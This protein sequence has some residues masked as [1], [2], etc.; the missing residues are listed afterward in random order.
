MF[1][2]LSFRLS[3]LNVLDKRPA[4]L[5][6]DPLGYDATQASPLGRVVK[7]GLVKDW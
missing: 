2:G 5:R 6:E 3:I 1:G 7:I 4:Y